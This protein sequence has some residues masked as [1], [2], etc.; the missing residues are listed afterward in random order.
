MELKGS[1]LGLGIPYTLAL[2]RLHT[3]LRG[4]DPGWGSLQQEAGLLSAPH[5]Y[6]TVISM[7]HQD[8]VST[9]SLM[10]LEFPVWVTRDG[11]QPD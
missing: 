7:C 4:E 1:L 6:G 5:Y 10:P 8:P 11:D 2:L 3:G 9:L